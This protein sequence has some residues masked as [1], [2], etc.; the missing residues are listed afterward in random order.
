MSI[1]GAFIKAR[2]CPSTT[3]SSAWLFTDM[4]SA[5]DGVGGMRSKSGLLM[6]S[7]FGGARGVLT[8]A[9]TQWPRVWPGLKGGQR[10]PAHRLLR[11]GRQRVRLGRSS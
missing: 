4:R 5:R 7:D 1:E 9:R 11:Y 6:L 8:I 10:M 3:P 2:L